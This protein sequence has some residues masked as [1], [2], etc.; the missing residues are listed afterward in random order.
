VCVESPELRLVAEAL[1]QDVNRDLSG[2][3]SYHSFDVLQPRNIQEL[4][5]SV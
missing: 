2:L 1:I 5:Q 4:L 3:Q